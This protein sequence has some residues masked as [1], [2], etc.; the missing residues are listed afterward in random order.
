V[1]FSQ[2]GGAGEVAKLLASSQNELGHDARLVSL[3]E[4]DLRS[5]PL[6]QPS[7]SVAAALDQFVVS[8]HSSPTILSLFRSKLSRLNRNKIRKD[9]IVHLHWVPGVMTHNDVREL[10]DQG[11]K[12]VWTLHD[13]APFT[14]VCHHSHGCEGFQKGC[15]ACPQVR[16]FYQKSVA[17]NLSVKRFERPEKNLILVAPT[18]WVATLAQKSSVFRNQRIEVIENPIRSEFFE[19]GD[20][21]SIRR[22]NEFTTQHS[23]RP[24]VLTAVASDL[25]N[26]AKGISELIKVI[27]KVRNVNPQVSIQLVG[28]RGENFHNPAQG[29]SW[30]G[31]LGTQGVIEIAQK[32]DL[33]ISASL[34]ESAGLIVR[35]FGALGVPT[36]ALGLGGISD[37]IED[38]RSG[39][40]VANHEALA[41]KILE[42]ADLTSSRL[43]LGARSKELAEQNRPRTIAQQ[44]LTVYET[45]S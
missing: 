39:I 43:E 14:G 29:V 5:E 37:L 8:N 6:A 26:P 16:S 1:S 45:L 13:M 15:E 3:L 18:P 32:T 22:L 24:L 9:S 36:L 19:T 2:S 17:R 27:A 11:R 7:I 35:E 20:F 38:G 23:I 34:A 41:A 12:V 25:R 42:F 40:I 31:S 21:D 4:R 44:Y 33:L 28:R 10:L 30:I